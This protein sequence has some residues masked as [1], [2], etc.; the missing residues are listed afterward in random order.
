MVQDADAPPSPKE[1]P[2]ET[3]DDNTTNPDNPGHRG[4]R[5]RGRGRRGRG[6]AREAAKAHVCSST[7]IFARVFSFDMHPNHIAPK[8]GGIGFLGF[9][10]S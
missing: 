5:G 7:F 3:K 8:Y 2:P 4:G 10:Y 9:R 1:E 6:T